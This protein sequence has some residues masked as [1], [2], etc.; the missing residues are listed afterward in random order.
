MTST[1]LNH[2]GLG[3]GF[4]TPARAP[5]QN[6][7]MKPPSGS[8]AEARF[9][10]LPDQKTR[11]GA[12]GVSMSV[13]VCLVI[14]FLALPL[15]FPEKL[16]PKLNFNVMTLTAP[17]T[18]IP[19]PKP[20]PVKLK[21]QPVVVEQPKP[22]PTTQPKMIV[23]RV[24]APKA[25]KVERPVEALKLNNFE[26]PKIDASLVAPSAPKK[27]IETGTFNTGSAATPT[28][29]KPTPVEKVQTGGFGDPNG[30]PGPGD[31]NKHANINHVGGFDMPGGPGY[32]NGTGGANG[33]RG[34]VQSAGFGNGTAIV[35]S[36]NGGGNRGTVQTGGFSTAAVES[37][38][39]KTHEKSAEAAVQPV[40]ILD[41]PKPEYTA[42][43]RSAKIEG[44]VVLQV[45][46]KADGQ[47]QVL[48]VK[49]GLGHGLD[50][51]AEKAAQ[52]I[53]YKPAIS[54][55]QPVDFPATVHIVFQLAY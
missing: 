4:A 33:A 6:F 5:K 12:M 39:P 10:L 8:G 11:A 41:K 9:E 30:L 22:L 53:R 7:S 23:P 20:I 35:P 36:G 18:E 15:F 42:D 17:L 46:F 48:G 3:I 21:P 2:T 50:E 43:A 49:Q 26:A 29:T 37:D 28:I 19:M 34:T 40:E 1:T 25:P 52:K 31:P 24:V 32:G 45:V 51:S 38:K 16:V 54:N 14:F 44:D 47:I 55:G 27:P 13:Q